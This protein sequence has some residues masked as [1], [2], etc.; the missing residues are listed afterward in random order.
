[1]H[2]LFAASIKQRNLIF[3]NFVTGMSPGALPVMPAGLQLFRASVAGAENDGGA[4]VFL[5]DCSAIDVARIA[6]RGTHTGLR[7]ERATT[8][9]HPFPMDPNNPA[10]NPGVGDVTPYPPVVGPDG[11]LSANHIQ[12]ALGGNSKYLTLAAPPALYTWSLFVKAASL[13]AISQATGFVNNAT[14]LSDVFGFAAGPAPAIWT[15]YSQSFLQSGGLLGF[16]PVQGADGTLWGPPPGIPAGA[17][18]DLIA[19]LQ[20]EAGPLSTFISGVRAGEHMTTTAAISAIIDNFGYF[21]ETVT[22]VPD[23]S[24]A[25]MVAWGLSPP[26]FWSLG[27]LN[28]AEINMAT[29]GVRVCVGGT[30]TVLPDAVLPAWASGDVLSIT[31]NH[32]GSGTPVGMFTLNGGPV[33]QLG[34]GASL[35]PL[36]TAG[37]P[38]DLCCNGATQE[39]QGLIQS[40]AVFQ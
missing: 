22:W 40:L 31:L 10:L 8:N 25:D 4:N 16:V 26:R 36:A 20:L 27:A 2:A 39:L 33:V 14:L 13:G 24:Y 18:D 9:D 5:R 38:I 32:M 17:R 37:V 12:C 35:P 30:L 1:M 15:R 23:V 7:L 28:Y 21:S 3:A 34:S 29:R 11:V 19:Y 6:K